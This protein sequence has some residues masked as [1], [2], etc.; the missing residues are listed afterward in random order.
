MK[1]Y[2][3]LF[4][5]IWPCGALLVP[6]LW[7]F[8]VYKVSLVV[9]LLS[10]AACILTYRYG[11]VKRLMYYQYARREYLPTPPFSGRIPLRFDSFS[12]L[13]DKNFDSICRLFSNR[14]RVLTRYEHENLNNF[15]AHRFIKIA[16]EKQLLIP[17]NGKYTINTKLEYPAVHKDCFKA[18]GAIITLAAEA[19]FNLDTDFDLDFLYSIF[20]DV[21]DS[22]NYILEQRI[23]PYDRYLLNLPSARYYHDD[24]IVL[25]VGSR[26]F[27]RMKYDYHLFTG[28]K[29]YK[30]SE[31]E[32]VLEEYYLS[33]GTAPQ[34]WVQQGRRMFLSDAVILSQFS[35]RKD[36][37]ESIWKQVSATEQFSLHNWIVFGIDFDDRYYKKEFVDCVRRMSAAERK[38]IFTKLTGWQ[39]MPLG[40]SIRLPSVR[41]V[42]YIDLRDS[43]CFDPETLTLYC[44]YGEVCPLLRKIM[45][46]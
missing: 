37:V 46:E 13:G 21:V 5:Y 6:M 2:F 28:V 42:S 10:V 33:V 22:A 11:R 7:P 45:N 9:V 35:D 20:E 1:L 17:V 27:M 30:P 36:L 40:G 44:T 14:D 25:M 15:V 18:V 24:S 38:T 43:K 4:K 12:N 31:I 8:V 34:L 41:L 29:Y 26:R 39:E 32:N 3:L 23:E 16:K 19:G